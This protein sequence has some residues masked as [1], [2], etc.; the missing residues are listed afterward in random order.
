MKQILSILII[1][2]IFF[3]SCATQ[4]HTKNLPKIILPVK[5]GRV[6]YEKTIQFPSVSKQDLFLRGR[7]W[8]VN[9]FKDAKEVLQISDKKVG[10]LTG[11]GLF[12]LFNDRYHPVDFTF[13]IQ[14]KDN[15]YRVQFYGF[16]FRSIDPNTGTE[17]KRSGMNIYKNYINGTAAQDKFR[18][19]KYAQERDWRYLNF[20]K[21][22]MK[23]L[24]RSLYLYEV[25]KYNTD[26]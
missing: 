1:T 16:T 4:K 17:L 13:N 8:A 24:M 3:S 23:S 5:N 19:Q 20:F 7:M 11:K 15:K 26:F 12:Y 10:Q 22:K 9:I 21:K 25:G 14:Y 6:F 2:T 18:S